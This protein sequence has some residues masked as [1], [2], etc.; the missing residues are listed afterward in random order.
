LQH[1]FFDDISLAAYKL[2]KQK[3]HNKANQW[4]IVP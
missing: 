3:A 2:I 1:V 4:S